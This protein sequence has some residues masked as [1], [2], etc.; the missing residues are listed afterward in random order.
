[1]NQFISLP[2]DETLVI[3]WPTPNQSLRAAPEKFFARTRVNPDF[4]KPGFTRDCGKRF[5]RG[6]D[7]APVKVS[8]TGQ[9]TTVLF[10]DCATGKDYESVEPTFVPHDDVFCGYAG[11]V[12]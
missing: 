4:G 11:T 7:I 9:H 6:C 3:A 1:M 8:P 5:H 10:T 12:A 2:A